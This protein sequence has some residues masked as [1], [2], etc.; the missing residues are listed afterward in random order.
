MRILALFITI[1]CLLPIAKCVDWPNWRGPKCDGISTEKL[2]SELP[3]SLPV[4]WTTE[5]GT[6]FCTVSVQGGRVLTMGNAKGKDTVWCL[7][8]TDGR[9]LWKHTYDCPLDPRYYEG[10]PGS[11]P[12]IYGGSGYTPVSYT[13]L[14]AHET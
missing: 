3:K 2:P 12:T 11:T 13:H 14:R 7:S 10:G 9:V 4:A 6:G 8:A 1:F 5:V